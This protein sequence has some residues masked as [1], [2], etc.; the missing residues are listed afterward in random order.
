MND[1]LFISALGV[2]VSG[3]MVG[4]VFGFYLEV[5]YGEPARI[6]KVCELRIPRNEHCVL[7]AVPMKEKPQ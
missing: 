7:Y 4:F 2:F 3:L 5:Y 6:I 1:W